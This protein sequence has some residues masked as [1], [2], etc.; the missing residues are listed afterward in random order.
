[1]YVCIYFLLLLLKEGP[2]MEGKKKLN[3]QC[4]YQKK[5][6]R[7]LTTCQKGMRGRAGNEDKFKEKKTKKKRRRSQPSTNAME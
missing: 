5:N 2:Y 6:K 7:A 4:R 1:M 3:K